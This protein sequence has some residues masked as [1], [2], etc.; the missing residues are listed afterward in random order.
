MANE[1]GRMNEWTNEQQN[2]SAQPQA[3]HIYVASAT[4]AMSFD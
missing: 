4:A 3:T 2:R 1:W